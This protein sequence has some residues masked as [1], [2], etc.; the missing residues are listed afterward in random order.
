MPV[1]TISAQAGT[2]ADQVAAELAAAAGVPLLDRNAL[3]SLAHDIDPDHLEAEE[4]RTSRD[5]TA[6]ASQRSPSAWRSRRPPARM[7]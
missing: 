5:A 6:D 7:P 2:G 1:W 3:A 4:S